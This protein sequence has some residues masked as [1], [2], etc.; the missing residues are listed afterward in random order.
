MIYAHRRRWSRCRAGLRWTG[1][2]IWIVCGRS[3]T[4]FTTLLP[5]L[6]LIVTAL[7]EGGFG[8]ASGETSWHSGEGGADTIPLGIAEG[9]AKVQMIDPEQAD[10]SLKDVFEAIEGRHHHPLVSS[11]YRGLGNW[12]GFL[13]S[14]W[15]RIEPRVGSED[16]EERKRVLVERARAGVRSLPGGGAGKAD[17]DRIGT[18]DI[19]AILAAFRFKF[20]PEMLIDVTLI[21]AMLDGPEVATSSRFSSA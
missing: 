16:Y 2:K 17:L 21:K 13:R 8:R 11:Y 15:G 9:T 4:A 7:A 3:T 20:I 19:R 12:P 5:K 6:L 10:D 1:S 18:N 14:A